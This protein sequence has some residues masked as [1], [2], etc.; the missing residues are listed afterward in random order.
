MEEHVRIDKFLWCVRLYKTRSLATD[1]CRKG[2]VR[3][4]DDPVKPSREVRIDDTF[5]I[6][7]HGVVR[8][9]KVLALLH[10]RVGAKWVS[11]YIEDLTP[12]EEYDKYSVL[13]G[14]GFERRERGTGRP[15]KR[16]R[17]DIDRLKEDSG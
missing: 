3:L 8:R 16:D 1:I 15:T 2:K 17:R 14:R 9:I 13:H 7:D 11:Q 5:T 12:D 4:N 6:H 10:N